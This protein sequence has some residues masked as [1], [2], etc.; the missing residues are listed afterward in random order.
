MTLQ[1]AFMERN[2]LKK[3]IARLTDDLTAVVVTEENETP[4]W[5]AEEKLNEVLEL[6]DQLRSLNI[7]IDIANQKNIELLQEMR[8]LEAKISLYSKIRT[9][10]VA[11][12]RSRSLYGDSVI[13]YVKHLDVDQVSQILQHLEENKRYLDRQIQKSNWQTEI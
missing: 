5:N 8:T 1:E 7:R 11:S 4:V 12:K 3:K 6:Q 13:T 10:L 9:Q 2:D